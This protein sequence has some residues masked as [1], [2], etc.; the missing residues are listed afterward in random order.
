VNQAAAFSVY[1]SVYCLGQHWP[2][3]WCNYYTGI[4]MTRKVQPYNRNVCKQ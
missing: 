1:T 3:L 4:A 2:Q